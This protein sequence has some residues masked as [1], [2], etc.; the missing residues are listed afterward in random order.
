MRVYCSFSKK[1]KPFNLPP[2]KSQTQ[3]GLFR[4]PL[5]IRKSANSHTIDLQDTLRI[6]T[7]RKRSC[8]K[9]MF[10][11]LSTS[12]SVHGGVYPSM[13][14]GRRVCDKRVQVGCVYKGM[15]QG[16]TPLHQRQPLNASYWNAFLLLNE[17][18]LTMGKERSACHASFKNVHP[19]SWKV[20]VIRSCAYTSVIK[21]QQIY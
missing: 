19:C 17:S 13:Q 10:L 5:G 7:S 4:F 20:R 9:V 3:C 21:V 8:G 15:W 1:E 12:H 18:W 6:F 16:C 2:R 14:L 11:Y